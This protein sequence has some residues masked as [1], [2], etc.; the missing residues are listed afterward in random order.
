MHDMAESGASVTIL[1][2]HVSSKAAMAQITETV[3]INQTGGKK[4]TTAIKTA[5][6]TVAVIIRVRISN[7]PF[8]QRNGVN[9]IFRRIF[10]FAFEIRLLHGQAH[11]RQT[12]AK[13]YP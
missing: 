9:I 8:T 5:I 4:Y 11:A 6:A 2:F 10:C 13:A 3:T 7:I 12:P 1:L